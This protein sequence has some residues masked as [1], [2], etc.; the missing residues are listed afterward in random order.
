V[1]IELSLFRPLTNT[2]WNDLESGA[3]RYESFIGASVAVRKP[4]RASAAS[5]RTDTTSARRAGT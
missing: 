5:R 2:E 3:E 1:E 4:S